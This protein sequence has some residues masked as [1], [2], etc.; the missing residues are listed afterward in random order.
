MQTVVFSFLTPANAR[1]REI[2]K[3]F[4]TCIKDELSGMS[5]GK[6]GKVEP[7]SRDFSDDF[8]GACEL[9]GLDLFWSE[10]LR[11]GSGAVL[12]GSSKRH[13]N[14][15]FYFNTPTPDGTAYVRFLKSASRLLTVDFSLIHCFEKESRTQEDEVLEGITSHDIQEALPT[16]AW[17][18]CFGSPYIEL[19][20]RS[21]L[22][23]AGFQTVESLT[24]NLSFC[25]LTSDPLDYSSNYEAFRTRQD[26]VKSR[27][28]KHYFSG[29]SKAVV[30]EF[31]FSE[32]K[33]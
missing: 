2:A 21:N 19:L 9:W 16:V 20:G 6:Y 23:S 14:I 27:L 13:T 11:R 24:E 26:S 30:P 5:L 12:H 18:N 28:G 10:S 7:L 17:A 15:S 4:F 3:A 31:D 8:D 29:T 33:S 1:S 32:N 25:Q 22:E